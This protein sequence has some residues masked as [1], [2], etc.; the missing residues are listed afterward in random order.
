MLAQPS[1]G[2]SSRAARGLWL[3]VPL[4]AILM[5]GA[6]AT[7]RS[8]SVSEAPRTESDKTD[9]DRRVA[10][11]LE[12]AYGYF[13]RGQ[14]STALDELKLA[15]QAKPQQREALNLRGLVYGAMGESALAEASFKQ[16]LSL[17]AQDPDTL[18]NY[19]LFLCR[20]Q[21]WSEARQQF[22]L[23]VAQPRYRTPSRTW[24]ARGICEA[25]AGDLLESERSLMQAFEL[26]PA[27]PAIS[28]NLAEVLFRSGQSERARF[29]IRRVNAQSDQSNAQTLW[30]GLRIERRMGNSASVDDL[31]QQLRRRYPQSNELR[32]LDNGRFDE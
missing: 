18:H 14:Y 13:S 17:A 29:Y 5:L 6:C 3:I 12:L 7:P 9:V 31:A 1:P 10:V 16:A 30:L 22:E 26:E 20:Q 19:G 2:S 21:R 4:I 15:L 24:L 11:R 25:T 8:A 27:N 23:A 32:S 28:F